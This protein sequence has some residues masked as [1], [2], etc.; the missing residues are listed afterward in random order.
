MLDLAG[1]LEA[2]GADSTT[3][4]RGGYQ[5]LVSTDLGAPDGQLTTSRFDQLNAIAS[6]SVRRLC[7]QKSRM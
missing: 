3:A 5:T 6:S 7:P 1:N 4:L 2:Q